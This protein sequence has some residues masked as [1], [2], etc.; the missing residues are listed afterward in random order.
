MPDQR[1]NGVVGRVQV[2][3]RRVVGVA[4]AMLAYTCLACGLLPGPDP[5]IS[6]CPI[7]GG[8][9]ATTFGLERA[10]DVR[11]AIPRMGVSPELDSNDHPA[12]VVIFSGPVDLPVFGGDPRVDAPEFRAQYEGVVCVVVDNQA[13]L[14]YDV[15]TSELNMP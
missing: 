10:S 11:T 4:L 13:N 2:S 7:Q 6:L 15:D 3:G 9:V 14:Y 1:R 5:R 8:Q 12:L